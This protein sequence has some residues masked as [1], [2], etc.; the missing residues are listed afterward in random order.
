MASSRSR[1]TQVPWGTPSRRGPGM[2]S[3]ASATTLTRLGSERTQHGHTHRDCM[4]R[5]SAAVHGWGVSPPMYVRVMSLVGSGCRGNAESI[6][7]RSDTGDLLR[8]V[9]ERVL[10]PSGE[11]GLVVGASGG[12]LVFEYAE[13]G[14]VDVRLPF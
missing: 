12:F 10:A 8:E 3:P 11:R 4:A 1:M 14:A 9:E 7:E 6:I 13:I 5:I 2:H